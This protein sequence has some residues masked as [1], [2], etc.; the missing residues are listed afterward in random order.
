MTTTGTLQLRTPRGSYTGR[1]TWPDATGPG[2]PAVLLL[3][4]GPV[5]AHAVVLQL[6]ETTSP[7]DAAHALGWLADHAAELGA[8]PTRLAVAG[9]PS[10]KGTTMSHVISADGTRIEY[11]RTGDRPAG[12]AVVLINAGPTDRNANAELAGLLSGSCTVFNYDRRGRGG[13]GDTTPHSPDREIEDLHA[14][15]TAAGGQAHVFAS[16]GGAFIALPAAA[17]GVPISSI[18]L[19]EPPYA[20]GAGRPPVPSDYAAHMAELSAQNR[21]G[22]M[23]EYFLTAAA[24]MPAEIVGGMRQAP[25]WPF[26]EAAANPGLHYDAV[27][28]G[29]FS[30]PTGVLADVPCPV[31]VLDGGTTPW[32]TQAADAVAEAAP[33]SSRQTLTG[34][35]HDVQPS[36][37]APALSAYF[38]G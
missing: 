10:R 1:L 20:V 8:D 18:A 35:Q 36:A 24:G 31:L 14:V 13:S 25:F 4:C 27:I 11:D 2:T 34:Q 37:L 21:P 5:D 26:L 17:A 3:G 30:V 32:L 28:A 38:T 22:D 33:K 23:V 16:S 29:D 19:W 6:P 7:A 12:P 15:V 9:N